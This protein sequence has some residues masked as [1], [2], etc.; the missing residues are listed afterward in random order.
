MTFLAQFLVSVFGGVF[1]FFVSWL[2]KKV[3]FGAAVTAVV[4][5]VTAVFYAAVRALV[6]GVVMTIDD[7]YFRMGFYMFWPTNA[8]VCLAAIFGSELAGY[9]YRWKLQLFRLLAMVQ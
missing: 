7:T 4:L 9:I 8:E 3:A 6:V 5:A 2:G 1:S